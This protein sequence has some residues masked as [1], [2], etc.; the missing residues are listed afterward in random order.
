MNDI[1]VTYYK[2][3]RPET[4]VL[5]KRTNRMYNEAVISHAPKSYGK[6]ERTAYGNHLGTVSVQAA[7]RLFSRL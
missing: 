2:S 7:G 3:F 1:F 6:P 4:F 5:H